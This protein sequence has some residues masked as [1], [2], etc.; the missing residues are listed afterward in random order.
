MSRMKSEMGQ[1]EPKQ[2]YC[3]VM[4]IGNKRNA[5]AVHPVSILLAA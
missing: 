1:F 4:L 5:A 3:N 2:L